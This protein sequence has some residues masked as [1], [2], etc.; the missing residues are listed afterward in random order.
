MPCLEEADINAK[1]FL[2]INKFLRP[3]STV[4]SLEL[5]LF[6]EMAE[7]YSTIKFSRLIKCRLCQC[8]SDWMDSL[9][10]F[11]ANTP[12]L[13]Y[14]IVDYQRTRR[15]CTASIA[16]RKMGSSYPE[17][18]L[19]SLE[20]FELIDYRGRDEEQELVEYILVNSIR[21][22]TVTISMASKLKNKETIMEKLKAIRRVSR[23]SQ[24]LFTT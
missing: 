22:K 14:L 5:F 6:D 18:F 23:A 24:L 19:T 12:K 10:D 2:V 4:L 9:V 1:S 20:K 3:I 8:D 21:L 11:L 17:C 16:W 15:P 13:T 7:C